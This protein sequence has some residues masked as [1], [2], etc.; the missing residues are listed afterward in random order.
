MMNIH[1]N[2]K[3]LLAFGEMEY[4]L[5]KLAEA[6][7]FIQQSHP[8]LDIRESYDSVIS[9]SGRFRSINNDFN[10]GIV[11]LAALNMEK[12]K[13]QRGLLQLINDLPDVADIHID[14]TTE[15][16]NKVLSLGKTAPVVN[17]VGNQQQKVILIAGLVFI[18]AMMVFAITKLG[19]FGNP[20]DS[21]STLLNKTDSLSAKKSTVDSTK[22][23][24]QTRGIKTETEKSDFAI[25]INTNKGKNPTL[26]KDELVKIYFTVT[27]PCYVRLIYR[28]AD[29]SAILLADNF[30]VIANQVNKELKA[31]TEFYCA[32]PFGNEFLTVYAQKVP[33]EKLRIRNQDGYEIITQPLTDAFAITER[34]LKKNI[35]LLKQEM[36]FVTREK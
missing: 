4:T 7:K 8:N 21:D 19:F 16:N 32:A 27:Q 26:K 17:K 9:F 10:I 14:L 2:F 33:F 15:L 36:K 18:A 5:N 6:Y 12:A 22:T 31:P 28:M 3:Q 20:D 25:S 1:E 34:G 23:T 24:D 30:E 29:G 13:I 11:D 35:V